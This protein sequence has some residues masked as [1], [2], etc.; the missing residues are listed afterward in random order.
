MAEAERDDIDL[1]DD[2]YLY[3]VKIDVQ[4]KHCYWKKTND[5]NG[6]EVYCK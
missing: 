5:N 3:I 1:L 6:R 4:K 2:V